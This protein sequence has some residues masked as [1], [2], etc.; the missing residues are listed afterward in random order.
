MVLDLGNVD[1]PGHAGALLMDDFNNDPLPHVACRRPG[2]RLRDA[3]A[4]AKGTTSMMDK[5]RAV[6]RTRFLSPGIG[7]T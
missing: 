4:F 3:G 7:R 1:L 2:S 5:F 6:A